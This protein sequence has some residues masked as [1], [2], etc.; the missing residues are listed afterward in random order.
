MNLFKNLKTIIMKKS[1]LILLLSLLFYP[2]LSRAQNA[3]DLYIQINSTHCDTN[4]TLGWS[5]GCDYW[6]SNS[7]GDSLYVDVIPSNYSSWAFYLPYDSLEAPYFVNFDSNCLNSNGTVLDNYSI[8]VNNIYS[9]GSYYFADT[10]MVCEANTPPSVINYNVDIYSCDT[11]LNDPLADAVGCDYWVLDGNGSIVVQSTLPTPT[12]STNGSAYVHIYN[13]VTFPYDSLA[14][15]Y[16]LHFDNNCLNSHGLMNIDSVLLNKPINWGNIVYDSL[17]ICAVSTIPSTV[18]A[19][20]FSNCDSLTDLGLAA[21]CDYWVTDLNGIV[22]YQDNIPNYS[23]WTFTFPYDPLEAP[24]FINFDDS[25]LNSSSV[26]LDN[27]TFEI[28]NIHPGYNNYYADTIIVCDNN[29]INDS[30]TYSV[31]MLTSSCDSIPSANNY[32]AAGCGYWV[33]DANGT[34]VFQSNI[35]NLGSSFLLGSLSFP[36]NSLVAPYTLSFDQNCLNNNGI[37]FDNYTF[38]LNETSTS[39]GNIYDNINICTQLDSNFVNDSCVD[40]YSN[41]GPWIGYYQNYINYIDFEMGNNSSTPQSVTVE[42]VMPPGVTPVTSSFD[43]PYSVSGSLLTLSTI[44]PAYSNYFDI[45]KFNVPGSIPNGTLHT[46]GISISNNDPNAVDCAL[47]NNQDTLHQIVGNSYDPNAKTVG[48]PEKISA[49]TQDEFL[50]TIYFQNTGTAPAQDIYILDTLSENLDWSTFEF[51]RSSHVVG[52]SDLGNGIKKFYF[53][54]IWLPDSTTDFAASNGFVVFKIKE[55]PNNS[56]GTE[57]FNTAHIFF[58]HNP[59][60]VTNTTYNINVDNL[61]LTDLTQ[62]IDV[63]LFPNPA[64]ESISIEADNRIDNVEIYSV[65]GKLCWSSTPNQSEVKLN[66]SDFKSGLY[67]VRIQSQDITKTLRFI[68]N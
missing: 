53:N 67:L 41:V 11:T 51:M 19:N 35:G 66:I 49:D 65:D 3:G 47:W 15:P 54:G 30:I 27:Y 6:V 1:V 17:Y 14:A 32:L 55:K 62:E 59:A 13:G 60:I 38:L 8:Q 43:F 37:L 29:T 28:T 36:Y 20:V 56:A 2:F 4:Q 24:Y 33:E 18:T 45:I 16:S 12:T 22:V 31:M 58:D 63:K 25:C 61:G 50:Y 68:K 10:V 9:Y 5:V 57:V 44:L 7:N 64:N 42:I 26:V 23:S 46:Y 48:L 52:I 40:L 39:G 21:G 34:I